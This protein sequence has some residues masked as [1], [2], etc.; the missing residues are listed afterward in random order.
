MRSLYSSGE[1]YA[2]HKLW[3]DDCHQLYVEECGN[4][5]GF[6]VVFLHGGPGSGCSD[7]HRRYFDPDCYR[8]IL[9]DQRG[10]GRSTPLGETEC[11]STL[12]LV[13][14]METIRREL[15]IEQWLLFG[16]SW[17]AALALIYA[18]SYPD[19]VSGMVLRGAF[20]AR[21]TDLEWFFMG[22]RRLFP[23]AWQELLNG[24]PENTQLGD[25][26]DWYHTAVHTGAKTDAL[27]AAR[28]WSGWGGRIVN[29]HKPVSE[30]EA[31]EQS[32]SQTR[33]AR[34]LA[35][36]KIETHY[37]HNRYFIEENEILNRIGSLRP[38]PVSIVHGRFDLTC[39]MEAAWLLHRA[40]PG[41]R[42]VEVPE[43][44]HLIDEPAMISA[45]IDETD[46]MRD[47]HES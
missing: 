22:L 37:A 5:Q 25:L 32:D 38:M 29:W 20:L 30:A 41:S 12:D 36:V 8:I 46:R 6:P 2:V 3:V 13:S 33:Q 18:L 9:F 34:L 19:R 35:K 11:N 26:I 7:Y 14:D 16:G 15:D 40:I 17:G 28:E 27:H 45:L 42:F 4:S 31:G 44:G 10:S 21:E 39:T 47:L 23:Q 1:P 24:L 43:A